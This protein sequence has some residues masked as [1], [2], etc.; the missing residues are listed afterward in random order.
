M[1][2][3]MAHCEAFES[4]SRPSGYTSDAAFSNAFKRVMGASP[5]AWRARELQAADAFDETD[6][7]LTDP[8]APAR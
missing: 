3:S 6:A 7:P 8:I 2:R 4:G 1:A 5:S